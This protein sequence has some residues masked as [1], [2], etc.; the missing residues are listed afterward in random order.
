MPLQILGPARTQEEHLRTYARIDVALDT[1]P[2][3]GATT[4]CD[5]LWMGVPV[6]TLPGQTF[7]SR[8]GL[9]LLSV[10]GLTELVARD[11]DEYAALAAGLAGDVHGGTT[12]GHE[13]DDRDEQH[14]GRKSGR[15]REGGAAR[16][17]L[18]TERVRGR[19]GFPR[20]VYE[21]RRQDG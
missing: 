2:Y 4:T 18:P 9:G 5:A 1:F 7:A 21:G 17:S 12:G 13:R 15:R 11:A 10:V 6:V 20:E 3:N 19:F 16:R 14:Y 8:H